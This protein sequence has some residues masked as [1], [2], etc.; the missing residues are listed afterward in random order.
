MNA[1]RNNDGVAVNGFRW[2][3]QQDATFPVDPA[4]PSSNPDELLSL[5]FHASY[6]PVAQNGNEDT[7]SATITAPAGR[8]YVSVLPYSGYSI[9]GAP[10]EVVDGTESVTVTVQQHPIPTTQIALYLFHDN[11]PVNGAPDLP[12]ETNPVPGELGHVDWTQFNVQLEEPAGRYGVAGGQGMALK[13]LYIAS[14]TGLGKTHLAR[15]VATE[16]SRHNAQPVRYASAEGFTSEFVSA[17]RSKTTTEFKRRYRP[18]RGGL[19]VLEDVQFLAAKRATQL[20]FFHSVPGSR[21][22]IDQDRS[23]IVAEFTLRRRPLAFQ[24][25]II[26]DGQPPGHRVV[27][28]DRIDQV[29][30]GGIRDEAPSPE[31]DRIDLL[32]ATLPPPDVDRAIM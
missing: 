10:I 3:L 20:E 18:D 16:V 30:G 11:F 12:E 24:P 25:A 8:Y 22:P 5:G 4:N 29:M 28:I 14:A 17:L 31:P 26:D 9:S 21:H 19:L 27:G 15:A 2:I 23:S 1:I 7:G 13:Q 6:H 32:L